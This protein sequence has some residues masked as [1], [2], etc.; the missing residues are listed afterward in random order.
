MVWAQ[1]K[2]F[3]RGGAALGGGG[4]DRGFV[5]FS[6]VLGGSERGCSQPDDSEGYQKTEV[7]LGPSLGSV[8]RG[9][10]FQGEKKT[11]RV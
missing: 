10:V 11:E 1:T 6:G 9:D 5:G 7:I 2:V 8:Q 3:D 4:G